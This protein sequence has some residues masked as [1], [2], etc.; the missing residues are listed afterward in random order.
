MLKVIFEHSRKDKGFVESKPEQQNVIKTDAVLSNQIDEIVSIITQQLQMSNETA[1][2]FLSHVTNGQ[3]T[4]PYALTAEQAPHVL[5]Q[6]RN[7]RD[8]ALQQQPN[9]EG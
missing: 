5:N 6:V 8:N 9:Q 3:V 4:N 7:Y 1:M 2:Q